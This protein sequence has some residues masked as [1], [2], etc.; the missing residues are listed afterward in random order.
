MEE[1]FDTYAREL[2]RAPL[3]AWIRSHYLLFLGEGFD[4]FGRE[5]AA[6]ETLKEAAEFAESNQ[7]HQIAFKAQSALERVRS[8]P[9]RRPN[10]LR[11]QLGCP[12][13]SRLSFGQSQSFARR[14]LP[15]S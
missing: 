3:G 8:A 7:I 13:T 6:I 5:E 1:V 10:L 15:R 9:R 14:R 12:T 11:L 2:A 4:R